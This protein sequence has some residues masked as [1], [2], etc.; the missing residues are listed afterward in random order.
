MFVV[1]ISV[2][3]TNVIQIF[4]D[5]F[6]GMTIEKCVAISRHVEHNLERDE[7]DFELQVSSPGLTESFKVKEQYIK[8]TGKEITVTTD[9]GEQL[10]GLLKETGPEGIILETESKEKIEG[11]KQLIKKE[12]HL[13]YEQ[14]KSAKAVISFK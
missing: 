1:D 9:E 3:S 7:E 14:I 2:S 8:Y 4:V 13:K 5:S 6:D 10:Q 12:H 11:K